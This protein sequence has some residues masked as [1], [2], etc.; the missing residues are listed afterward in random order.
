MAGATVELRHLRYFVA[1]VET[2]NLSRA[3]AQVRL[4][5]PAMSRQMHDLERELGVTL[6]ERHPKGVTPTRAGEAF[7]RGA[8]QILA[9]TAAAL[10]RAEATAA[11]RRGRVV[12]GAMRAFVALGFPAGVQEELRRDHPEVT[13]VVQDLDPP[14]VFEQLRDGAID[15]AL[16][17]EDPRDAAFVGAS[18]WEETVDQALVPAAH[19]LARRRRVTVRD[20]GE[21]SLVIAQQGYS[22][23]LLERG[24]AALRSCGLRSPLL[25]I[26][27]GL[28]A[29][30]IAVAAGRG[31]TLLT[32][33][34]A[35]A[36]PEGT[37]VVRVEG[38]DFAV[39][40]LTL[41]R[42]GERRPVVRTVLEKVFEIARRRPRHRVPADL[43]HLP[44]AAARSTRRGPRGT[45]PPTM[46]LRH[47]RALLAVAGA[48]T[49][50]RA[51]EQLGVAQPSLS[52]QL[53]ELEQ[54]VG[55]PLLERSA[56]GVLLTPAGGSLAGDCP[57]L[58]LAIER[59]VQETTRARRGMEGRCVIGAVATVV[60]SELL[61][62][63]LTECAARH[64]HV[65]VLIEEMASP[66]QPSALARGATDLGLAHS[67]LGL[68]ERE[69]LVQERLGRGPDQAG[70][71]GPPQ[72]DAGRR[73]PT[74]AVRQPG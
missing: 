59:L 36:P 44:P 25:T 57:A 23:A 31:W 71:L 1:V 62:R 11:G 30:H 2:R 5:Q 47:L 24:L 52:R 42:R 54:A 12:L 33:A 14:D 53:K 19:R 37:A 35:L 73:Q 48:Q 20:L 45:I 3:A 58:L 51:A 4:A 60:T 49:I 34:R 29:A 63:A 61:T 66:L 64:P 56:R 55:V 21:L 16:A 69:G 70:L 65:R 7:A 40:P 17:A 22:G 13:L 46:E 39:L 67:Y 43:K 8:P 18:L 27:A 41:W 26:D 10:E 74:S 9:D 32:R 50:G 6:L 28:Q 68:G 38:I 15:L 72:S